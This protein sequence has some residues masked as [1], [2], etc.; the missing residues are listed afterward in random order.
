[1]DGLFVLLSLS[2]V[3]TVAS[4]LA[5]AL[6]LSLTFSPPQMRLISTLGMGVL[7]G[8]S[9]IVIIPEGIETLY[10]A[11]PA[12]AAIRPVGSPGKTLEARWHPDAHLSPPRGF[13]WGPSRAR[14]AQIAHREGERTPPSTA[15][16]ATPPAHPSTAD[17]P[18]ATPGPASAPAADDAAPPSPPPSRSPHASVGLSLVLGFILMYLIDKIPQHASSS[19][20]SIQ[21][22]H[23]ISLEHL[24]QG[25]HRTEHGTESSLA[26]ASNQRRHL[27]TT[28]GLVIHAA[29]DGI[30]LGAS[31][32]TANTRLGFTIFVAIMI[33][34]APAAFGLTSVLLKQ[35]WSKREARAHLVV[36][37]LAAPVG[38][39]ATWVL[40]HV[41]GRGRVAGP[42]E[43]EWWTGVLLLFSAGTFLYVA[44]HTMQE[45]N[46]LSGHESSDGYAN[47]SARPGR[48]KPGPRLQ[49]TIAA[50]AGMLIPLLTQVGHSH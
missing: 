11:R 49:D 26:P 22:P 13:L 30:A 50:V 48:A 45:E 28:T 3:M 27:S 12:T 16:S 42:A 31:S 38:A 9:L 36:F 44:M 5:G 17:R 41:A 35:G 8:T 40:V 33:H 39:I 32:T 20:Q 24:A 4:L 25:L 47:G 18:Q 34:K 1:M 7:V 21:P 46:H 15:R 14:L 29:A 6:P 2:T 10:N 37:S 43:T 19:V 23:H